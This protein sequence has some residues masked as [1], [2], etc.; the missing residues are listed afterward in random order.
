M[1]LTEVSLKVTW[2]EQS[3]IQEMYSTIPFIKITNMQM[4]YCVF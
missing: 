3:K 4:F 2:K 1:G